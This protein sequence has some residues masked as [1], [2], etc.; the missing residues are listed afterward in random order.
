MYSSLLARLSPLGRRADGRLVLRSPFNGLDSTPR[1]PG[2]V[3]TVCVLL[4]STAYDGLSDNPRW[5]TTLQTSPL[6]P[7]PTAT[8][9]LLTAVLLAA[10]CY[11]LCAG[12]L[13][14]ADRELT[15][16]SP[17]S[18]TPCRPSPSAISLPT[19]SHS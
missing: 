10:A 17:P 8:L 7:V 14:L 12:A 2:L 16:P 13:R 5:I 4:G 6:G 18:P 9:G 15:T 11:G 3:A 1:V 19:T